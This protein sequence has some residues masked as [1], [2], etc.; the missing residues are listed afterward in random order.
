MNRLV[1]EWRPVVGYEGLYE[2]SDWG[3]VR[4]VLR[5]EKCGNGKG[6]ERIFGGKIIKFAYKQNTK[7]HR[8]Y[9]HKKGEKN[10]WFSCHRL[11][12]E[13]FIPNPENKPCIDHIDGNPENNTVS[14]LRWVTNQE[15]SNNPITIERQ[16]EAIKTNPIYGKSGENHPMFG[17]HFSEDSKRKLSIALKGKMSGENNPMFGKHHTDEVKK[18]ISEINKG[19]KHTDEAKKKMSEARKGKKQSDEHKRK[20]AEAAFKEVIQYSLDGELVRIWKSIKEAANELGISGA[21]ISNCCRGRLKSVGGYI[22][23]YSST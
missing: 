9:L 21:N 8:Y 19:R 1:E 13:A 16:R 7:Y 23:K 15:N 18:K 5:V 3:R 2:V 17:K 10:K 12:A 4:S 14:N 22:W 11:V 6:S 20:R